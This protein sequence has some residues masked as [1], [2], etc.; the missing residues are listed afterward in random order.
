MCV[1]TCVCRL[2]GWRESE[3]ERERRRRRG[4]FIQCVSVF[5]SSSSFLLSALLAAA[6]EIEP[7][8]RLVSKGKDLFFLSRV[9][10]EC[11]RGIKGNENNTTTRIKVGVYESEELEKLNIKRRLEGGVL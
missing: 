1:C 10:C 11:T 6:S 5:S 9:C 2:A 4:S 3:G 7:V 8:V